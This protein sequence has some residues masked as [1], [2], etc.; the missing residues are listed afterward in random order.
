M[1]EA[2]PM[3]CKPLHLRNPRTRIPT[4]KAEAGGARL[5]QTLQT[6]YQ[7][8]A[9]SEHHLLQ[10]VGAPRSHQSMACHGGLCENRVK[11]HQTIPHSPSARARTV[12]E[13]Q[14]LTP[15]GQAALNG[16]SFGTG[17]TLVGRLEP[18]LCPQN[19]PK[20]PTLPA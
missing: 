11:T 4:L 14:N 10:P 6:A 13:P 3:A 16:A 17:P 15:W 1:P 8:K 9:L 7:W 18:E 5:G 20:S 2:H 19:H 12:V